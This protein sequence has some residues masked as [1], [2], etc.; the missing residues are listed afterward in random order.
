MT[1]SIYDE[2]VKC[3]KELGYTEDDLGKQIRSKKTC[4]FLIAGTVILG[5]IL[6]MRIKF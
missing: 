6:L 2:W 3:K 1:G 5:M 4:G